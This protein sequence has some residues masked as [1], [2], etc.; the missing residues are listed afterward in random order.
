MK[1]IFFL[2]LTFLLVS[3]M[4]YAIDWLSIKTPSGGLVDIDKDSIKEAQNY[5]FYNIK[6]TTKLNEEIII[7]MQSATH[8]AQESNITHQKNIKN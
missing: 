7:T 1:K 5:Y 8:F 3:Q 2:L 6:I 4:S